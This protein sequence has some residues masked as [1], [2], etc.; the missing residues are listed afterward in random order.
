MTVELLNDDFQPHYTRTTTYQRIRGHLAYPG[1]EIHHPNWVS[2]DQIERKAYWEGR[3]VETKDGAAKYEIVDYQDAHHIKIHFLDTLCYQMRDS[4]S[5]DKNKVENPFPVTD[6]GETVLYF[7]DP[8]KQYMG[9]YFY[10]TDGRKDLQEGKMPNP[11]DIYR[12]IEYGG[13]YNIRIQ[14]QDEYGYSCISGI[15]AIICGTIRNRYKYNKLSEDEINDMIPKDFENFILS[16]YKGIK[17]RVAYNPSYCNTII[18]NEWNNYYAF[19]DWYIAMISILNPKYIKEY[20]VDKD[21]K[22]PYYSNLTNNMKM[23]G[24]NTAVILPNELNI[25]IKNINDPRKSEIIMEC[26][27]YYYSENAITK[28]SYDMIVDQINK[29]NGQY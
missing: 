27:N 1:A 19:R 14:F 11:S 13:K 4:S 18:S 20:N 26:A 21:L 22:Y 17:H 12:I 29:A 2:Q 9:A 6:K 23:Y 25:R 3:V 5:L 28:E 10:T 8:Y 7:E 16:K 24:P 15:S